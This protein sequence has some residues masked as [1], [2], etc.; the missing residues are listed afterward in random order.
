L[1]RPNKAVAKEQ[2]AQR[3]LIGEVKCAIA[4]L[5]AAEGRLLSIGDELFGRAWQLGRMAT[6]GDA[7]DLGFRNHRFQNVPFRFKKQSIYEGKTRFFTI[8]SA[9]TTGE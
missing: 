8:S 2:I 1:S 6:L 3:S 4:E 9:F 7:P 5:A